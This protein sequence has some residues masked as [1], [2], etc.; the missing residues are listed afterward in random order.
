MNAAP[1]TPVYIEDSHA[2][3]YYFF[4]NQLDLT[5]EYQLIL[6]DK[7]SDATATFDSDSFRK[8]TLESKAD[9]AL[10]QLF[11]RWRGQ[12]LIQCFS[13]I[14]PLM[15]KPISQVLWVAGNKLSKKQR[16][17]QQIEATKQIN[18]HEAAW[19]RVCGSLSS[20][21][22]VTDFTSLCRQKTTQSPVI[23]SLDLDYFR[24]L[25]AAKQKRELLRV[26]DYIFSLRNLQAISVAVSYPY[27]Q[28]AAEADRLLYDLFKY[29]N[30]VKNLKLNFEPWMNNG[31]DRSELARTFYKK[32][33]PVPK[34]DIT[35]ASPTLKSL[36][37]NL[38]LKVEHFPEKWQ[39]LLSDWQHQLKS[40]PRIMVSINKVNMSTRPCHYFSLYETPILR[41]T[42]IEHLSHPVIHWLILTPKYKSINLTGKNYGFAD[43]APPWIIFQEQLI[44]NQGRQLKGADLINLFDSRIKFGTVRVLAEVV[45]D[46]TM[47]RSNVV[48]LTR[49]QDAGYLGR[50]TDIFNLPY[51]LGSSL[52]KDQGFVGPDAKYGADCSGFIIYG[53]RRLGADI[54]YLNPNQLRPYLT[55]L[56][57]VNGFKNGNA[58]GKKGSVHLNDKLL[59]AGLLLHFGGHIVAVYQDN[60]PK[61]ILDYN[62]LIIHQLEGFPEIVPLRTLPQ[63]KRSFQVMCFKTKWSR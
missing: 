14:E 26:L 20:R 40:L 11:Q 4:V 6:I 13:W 32:N 9:G 56:D 21:F 60:A 3:S 17:L 25:P 39:T 55:E 19:P 24:G 50:L 10:E 35:K 30:Q 57:T 1:Y 23:V 37:L 58:C 42:G 2:G 52:I 45:A 63:I 8:K 38:N 33:L 41:I 54:P 16:D 51:V 53:M 44:P 49:F 48:C 7:H 36:L 28:S 34:Y 43:N 18:C 15:P 31:P 22:Q 47:Y 12:G 29:L 5:K 59:H 27:L 61:N 62:D 46:Q